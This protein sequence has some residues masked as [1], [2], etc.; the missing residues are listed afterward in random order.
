MGGGL[1]CFLGGYGIFNEYYKSF[2]YVK[3]NK[4]E[5]YNKVRA[6]TEFDA[7]KVKIVSNTFDDNK[8]DPADTNNV[9]RLWNAKITASEEES[10]PFSNPLKQPYEYGKWS[11]DRS[12]N[13]CTQSIEGKDPYWRITT[14]VSYDVDTVA[15]LSKRDS[16]WDKAVNVEV[17]VDGTLCG[18][19]MKETKLDGT[20]STATVKEVKKLS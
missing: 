18:K 19:P 3:C 6:L 12:I 17:F 5:T 1:L 10:I 11:V 14:D 15:I 20:L 7:S 4:I 2:N 8:F 16:N 9:L 13:S